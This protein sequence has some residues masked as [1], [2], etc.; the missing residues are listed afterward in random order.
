MK[1]LYANGCSMTEGCELGN[2]QF[3]Y[4]ESKN[5]PITSR[6]PLY[7]L[8]PEHIS[9]MQTHNWSYILKNLLN[10]PYYKNSARS[11]SSSKRIVR[12][13]IVD[14][15]DLLT[16]YDAKDILVIIGWTRINRFELLDPSGIKY[17]FAPGTRVRSRTL[18][19]PKI[20]EMADIY[21]LYISQNLYNNQL[22]HF[23]DI[24]HM[25]SFLKNKGINYIFLYTTYEN[26][27]KSYYENEF[28]NTINDTTIKSLYSDIDNSRFIFYDNNNLSL[29]YRVRNIKQSSFEYFTYKN[30]FPIGNGHHP[31]E[32]AHLHWGEFMFNAIKDTI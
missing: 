12:T 3:N 9:H 17:Q 11:G 2:R 4:D 10:I 14:I 7:E 20:Q 23:S 6:L 29:E 27:Q 30:K 25:Q 18:L 28:I 22:E 21:E 26:M 16:R 5:G 1:I 32:E 13:S 8:S 19:H 31:L 24:I 15:L